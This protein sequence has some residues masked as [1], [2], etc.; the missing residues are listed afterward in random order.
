MLRFR[1]NEIP[2]AE[3]TTCRR[4]LLMSEAVA[5]YVNGNF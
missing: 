3:V 4:L 2:E 5:I 1:A